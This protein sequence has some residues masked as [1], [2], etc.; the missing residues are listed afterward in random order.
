MVEEE[1]QQQQNIQ[2][3]EEKIETAQDYLKLVEDMK[4]NYVRKD[5]YDKA[6]AD[7][8]ALAAAVAGEGPVPGSVQKQAQK[9]DITELRKEFLSAGEK[10]LSNAEYVK[11]A[12][13]LRNEAIARGELDPFLPQGAKISP[14]VDDIA[15]ANR[16]ADGLQSFLDSATDENGV[17]DN[18]V[19]NA[20]L[21][22]GIADD[23]AAITARL[24]TQNQRKAH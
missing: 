4:K 6:E 14:S 19:F 13:Q 18:D 23:G 2:K 22:K 21:K 12:L 7:R 1:K 20:F 16:V 10:N 3:Q 9:P 8:K 17:I 5:L 11:L 24:R 15:K